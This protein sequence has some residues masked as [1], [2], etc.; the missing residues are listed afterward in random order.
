M[1]H[2]QYITSEKMDPN[3]NTSNA[4]LNAF[5]FSFMIRTGFHIF[6]GNYFQ[7]FGCKCKYQLLQE[8]SFLRY[9]YYIL[10]IVMHFIQHLRDS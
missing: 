10:K 3:K 1:K 9:P 7:S 8:M 2:D 6:S 4:I 5:L